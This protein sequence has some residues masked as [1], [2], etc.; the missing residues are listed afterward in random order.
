MLGVCSNHGSDAIVVYDRIGQH[1]PICE[2]QRDNCDQTTAAENQ[3]SYEALAK[4]ITEFTKKKGKEDQ[5]I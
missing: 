3:K 1:C 2:W 4:T 5:P